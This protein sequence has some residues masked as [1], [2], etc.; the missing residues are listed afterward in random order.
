MRPETVRDLSHERLGW[1][2]PLSSDWPSTYYTYT[3]FPG[4]MAQLT[5]RFPW[6]ADEYGR[7]AAECFEDL[8]ALNVV[9]TEVS[10]DAPV[11]AVDDDT[12]FWPIMEALEMERRRAEALWPIRINFILG[13][14]RSLPVEVAIYRVELAAQAREQGIAVVG[15]DLHG[16]EI[17]YACAPFAPA[18][19]RGAE[20][21]LGLRCH[22]GEVTDPQSVID[23]IE[24]LG[25]K[26][27]AHGVRAV[28]NPSLIDRLRRGDITLEMCLTSNVRTG[29]IPD[30]RSH[31]FRRFFD[32]G[33][34]VTVNSDDPLPFFTNIE[35]EYRLLVDEMG[36]TID[37][38]R[39]TT[40]IAARAA[41][42]GEDERRALTAVIDGAYRTAERSVS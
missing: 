23:A 18:F 25:A 10:L 41:F 21:G 19:C 34:P 39:E 37:E 42:L 40:L 26:R 3:D 30:V 28:E 27:I 16:D 31:P 5:P 15:I 7:V 1:E 12:R 13:L 9:Y 11:R 4:F 32:A 33:I 36:F 22:A 8:V 2:G 35:R 6:R 24:L 38:L 20:L 17:N 29:A 14:Q